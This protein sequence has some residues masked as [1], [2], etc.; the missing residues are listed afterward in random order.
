MLY[1]HG[2]QSYIWNSVASRR[3]R[4]FGMVPI[5]GDLVYKGNMKDVAFKE[6][7]SANGTAPGDF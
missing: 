1:L 5:V 2:Y 6:E 4:E 3:L 7:S